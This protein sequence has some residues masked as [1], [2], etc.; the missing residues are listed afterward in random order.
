MKLIIAPRKAPQPITIG[1]RIRLASCQAPPGINGVR[2]G[3]II[4]FTKDCMRVVAATPIMNAIASGIILYS[5]KNCL[6]SDMTFIFMQ[7]KKGL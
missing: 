5:F 7:G 2:I 3:I 1:P 4:L 6:N